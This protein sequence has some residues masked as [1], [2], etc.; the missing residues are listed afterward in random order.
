MRISKRV[1][2]L[3]IYRIATL[4]T[5]QTS[6]LGVYM[7]SWQL[8]EAKAHFSELIRD[9]ISSGPQMVLV[10]GKEEAIVISKR[11]YDRLVGKKLNL[12]DFMGRSPLKGLPLDLTR[13]TSPDRDIEL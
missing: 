3:F 4:T 9:C 8:Q 6:C 2:L 5:S 10:R 1:P 7:L 11:D 12:V 13:D